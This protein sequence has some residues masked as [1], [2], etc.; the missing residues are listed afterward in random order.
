MRRYK[1]SKERLINE[2]ARCY[3]LRKVSLKQKTISIPDNS[4]PWVK[5]I[6]S[7]KDLL[8]IADQVSSLVGIYGPEG[9]LW[10]NPGMK[11]SEAVKEYAEMNS[12]GKNLL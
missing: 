11:L 8:Y 7:L 9:V 6:K 2:W 10:K 4:E 1:K 5:E 3:R 12:K